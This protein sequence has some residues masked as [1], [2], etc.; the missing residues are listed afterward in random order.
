MIKKPIAVLSSRLEL[1][2]EWLIAT[3]EI[4]HIN[5]AR[6][7]YTSNDGTRYIIIQKLDQARGWEFSDVIK[8]PDYEDLTMEVRARI[9]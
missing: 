5:K 9:R 4:H 8:A 2:I 3:K 1:T 6:H 7:Q